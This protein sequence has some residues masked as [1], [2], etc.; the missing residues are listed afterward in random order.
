[1]RVQNKQVGKSS[2]WIMNPKA[3]R[4]PN[5]RLQAI[6]KATK[7]IY[8]YQV[9]FITYLFRN[10]SIKNEEMQKKVLRCKVRLAL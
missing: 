1:M 9:K 6:T 2:L 10:L 7:K 4:S 3:T 8:F 5:P